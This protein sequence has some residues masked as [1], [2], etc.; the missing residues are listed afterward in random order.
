M[1][2]RSVPLK[3]RR[4]TLAKCNGVRVCGWREEEEDGMRGKHQRV[5]RVIALTHANGTRYAQ[6]F[7]YSPRMHTRAHKEASH[8]T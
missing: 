7:S 8:D 3:A 4:P 5:Q 2:A 6:T 1:L